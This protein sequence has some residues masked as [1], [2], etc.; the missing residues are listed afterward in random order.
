MH[1]QALDQFRELNTEADWPFFDNDYAL[2]N[3]VR[4]QIRPLSNSAAEDLW[5]NE[6]SHAPLERHVMLLPD[7]HWVKPDQQGPN[8]LPEWSSDEGSEVSL[9]LQSHFKISSS[10][11]VFFLIMREHAYQVP[12]EVLSKHWR[13]FLA[14]DDEGPLVLHPPSGHYALFG[15]NGYLFAGHRK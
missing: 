3:E 2:L 15:P 9:F 11:L 4:A 12:I 7:D 1:K 10:E 5:R 13:A 14:L 8:W 6:V